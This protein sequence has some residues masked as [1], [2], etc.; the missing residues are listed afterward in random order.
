[1]L[2]EEE[3]VVA[4]TAVLTAGVSLDFEEINVWTL[5]QDTVRGNIQKNNKRTTT[6]NKFRHGLINQM[7]DRR[8]ITGSS[9]DSWKFWVEFEN[10]RMFDDLLHC[11][12]ALEK[13]S[14]GVFTWK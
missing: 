14:P 9:K 6:L 10:L 13:R 11:V 4:F 3:N 2:A 12:K 5:L 1:M 8:K 7:P